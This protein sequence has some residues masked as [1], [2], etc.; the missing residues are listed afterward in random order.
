MNFNKNNTFVTSDSHFGHDKIR[1]HCNRPFSDVH[2]MNAILTNNW[3]SVVNTNFNVIHLGDFCFRGNTAET[4]LNNLNG[5]I[6]F[7]LGNHDKDLRKFFG[8]AIVKQFNGK[9]YRIL[10]AESMI[11]IDNVSI[12]LSHYAMRVWNGSHRGNWMLYGHSHGSLPDDPNS[13]SIDVGVDSNDYFPFT[14]DQIKTKMDKKSFKP[15]DHH[16]KKEIVLNGNDVINSLKGHVPQMGET[17]PTQKPGD[18]W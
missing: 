15:I 9:T 14:F 8:D 7:V 5:N 16:G 3:N 18:G 1:F 10:P 4:Y 13:L 11:T 12:I 6:W 17:S 2:H